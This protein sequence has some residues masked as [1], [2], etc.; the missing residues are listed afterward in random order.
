MIMKTTNAPLFCLTGDVDWASDYVIEDFLS[1]VRNYG[2]RPTIFATHKSPV[3]EEYSAKGLIELGIHPNFLPGSSQGNNE[4]SVIR[5]MCKEFP[6]AKAFRSH[7][8]FTN[9]HIVTEM[10][11][12]GFRYDSNLCLYLQ[13]GITPLSHASGLTSFPVFFEDDSH[14]IRKGVWDL[15][16]YFNHFLS[17]GLKILDFHPFFVTANIPD[18]KYYT[19]VKKHITTCAAKDIKHIRYKGE[20]A[21]TFF[22]KLLEGLSSR[23]MRF[24]T[25]SE[26]YNMFSPS[27]PQIPGNK[28]SGR[29][30]QHSEEDYKRYWKMSDVE[31]Q[32]FTRQSY[33]RRNAKDIYATS[34]DHNL[35]ELEV[36]GIKDNITEKGRVLDLGCGNGYTLISAAKD[37]KDWELIGVDLSDNLIKGANEILRS[38]KAELQSHPRF[39][40]A[41]AISY[42][43]QCKENSARYI[44]TERFIQNMPNAKIQKTVLR[45]AYRVLAPGGKL[46]MCEGSEDGFEALN[47]LRESVGLSRVPATSKDNIGAIRLKDKEVEAFV[48]EEIG[49]TLKRKIGFSTYFII[50]RVL[51]PL[52]VLPQSPGFDAKINEIAATIQK[53]SPHQTGYGSNTLWVLEK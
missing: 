16:R 6:D 28:K 15:D 26:L 13:S 33:Q 49:F 36:A 50:S 12:R 10:V 22:I 8:F 37:R 42:L 5:G 18:Q 25:L 23:G 3:L 2:I 21:R 35:R 53:N 45:E 20:G 32:E 14:Q 19:K 1:L 7:C 31:K 48:Q 51:H 44:V 46:L 40:S 34:R 11:K 17:P 30:T 9:S 38:Q 39:I 4:L 24:Y 41:D 29:H 47:N 52:L 43:K 27:E